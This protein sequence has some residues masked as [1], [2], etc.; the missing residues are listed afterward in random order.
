MWCLSEC[1][2]QTRMVEPLCALTLCCR[3]R[4]MHK[5]LLA[6]ILLKCIVHFMGMYIQIGQVTA[7]FVRSNWSFRQFFSAV[8]LCR[9]VA[10]RLCFVCKTH[11]NSLTRWQNEMN[12][13]LWLC[14]TSWV[15]SH[16]N[17]V[18]ILFCFVLFWWLSWGSAS[19]EMI[20][21]NMFRR[22]QQYQQQ[23]HQKYYQTALRQ[24]MIR[25]SIQ[26]THYGICHWLEWRCEAYIVAFEIADWK[27]FSVDKRSWR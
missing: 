18:W 21:P 3:L 13:I 26:S 11:T 7:I 17:R 1:V 9:F 15:Q 23:Q 4:F 27:S 8:S 14:F 6:H 19:N 2:K 16:W 10:L 25:H 22:V 20:S 12:T 5:H 24:L